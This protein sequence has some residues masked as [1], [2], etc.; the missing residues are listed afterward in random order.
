MFVR[1]GQSVWNKSN[2]F[3]GWVDI[4]LNEV[5]EQEARDAGK[6]LKKAG[7]EFDVA[8]TSMLKR[9]IVTL[10]NIN[11]E[12]DL[13]WIPVHKH[14][15]LNERHYGQLQ[16]WNKKETA[17]QYGEDQ[18]LKWRRSYDNPPPF[19]D[20]DDERHPRMDLKYQ[21]LPASVLP[22]GESLKMA[23]NRVIPYWQDTICPA[24]MSGKRAIVVAHE[25]VLRGIV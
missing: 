6:R 21:G 13:D 11:D 12:L 20:W 5:G 25:N 14:W 23:I 22:K 19:L 24:V 9:A 15:R 18:V 16:G 8:Y 7:F 1:H 3:S 4:P 10:N 17:E 2:R